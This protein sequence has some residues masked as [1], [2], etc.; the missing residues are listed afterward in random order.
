MH[1]SSILSSFV[2]HSEFINPLPSISPSTLLI[3]CS[4]ALLTCVSGEGQTAITSTVLWE[5]HTRLR[6]V[7][8]LLCLSLSG[9][10]GRRA[11]KGRKG[12]H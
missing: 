10:R 1:L 11:E 7:V 9:G 3:Q 6:L 5:F 4:P 12:C 8:V 2:F